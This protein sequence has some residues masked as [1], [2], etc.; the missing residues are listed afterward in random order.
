MVSLGHV[1]SARVG[2]SGFN[3]QPIPDTFG[4]AYLALIDEL[5]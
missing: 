3:I 1:H 2:V 4:A 5:F